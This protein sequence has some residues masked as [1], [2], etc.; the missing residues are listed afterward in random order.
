MGRS[1]TMIIGNGLFFDFEDLDESQTDFYQ[2]KLSHNLH[3]FKIEYMS[4]C[5]S[6]IFISNDKNILKHSP[7]ETG[8][9]KLKKIS[10]EKNCDE[11][12]EEIL[13]CINSKTTNK[14][15]TKDF[16]KFVN[17]NKDVITFGRLNFQYY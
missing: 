16:K 3:K 5:N 11:I 2:N 10:R 9:I 17:D 7:C 12:I 1:D 4:P 8:I 13:D 15:I 14:N 6:K